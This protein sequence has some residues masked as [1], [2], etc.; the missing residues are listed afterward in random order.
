MVE[1]PRGHL[2]GE[3]VEALPHLSGLELPWLKL[4]QLA[5][6]C[7]RCVSLWQDDWSSPSPCHLLSPQVCTWDTAAS[8]NHRLTQ[9][10]W[11]SFG[12]NWTASFNK[13]CPCQTLTWVIW[14]CV[15]RMLQRPRRGDTIVK[16]CLCDC[17]GLSVVSCAAKW[18]GVITAWKPSSCLTAA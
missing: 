16:E 1:L 3:P 12:L 9:P 7:S 2:T 8:S 15:G 6:G 13:L 11:P 4:A 18:N 10:T 5:V 14:V 17:K